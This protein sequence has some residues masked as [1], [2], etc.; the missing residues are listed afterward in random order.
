MR[1]FRRGRFREKPP[2]ER[3]YDDI[4]VASYESGDEIIEESY[5]TIVQGDVSTR[6]VYGAI[7]PSSSEFRI[8]TPSPAKNK[9]DGIHCTLERVEF[10]ASTGTWPAYE[11]L[12]YTWGDATV[13]RMIYVNRLPF[14]V[15]RNLDVA[16]RYLRQRDEPRVLWI[17]AV[18]IDQSN[19]AE[20]THQ[21]GMMGNI[22]RNAARVLVWLGESDKDIR[23]AMAFLQRAD[24]VEGSLPLDPEVAK[25]LRQPQQGN[26]R[27]KGK[28]CLFMERC[29]SFAPGI[30][31]MFQKPWW[32]KALLFSDA[33]GN[34]FRGKWSESLCLML[35]M[36]NWFPSILFSPNQTRF[37][38]SQ[39]W[40]LNILIVEFEPQSLL[41]CF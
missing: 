31:K 11:E 35:D 25:L 10:E 34:G 30:N 28:H 8:L 40:Y 7:D 23:K 22:Y 16:L 21:V 12:S 17:D 13:R 27:E 6:L 20:K 24:E 32:R 38:G 3:L 41:P 14:Q 2:T 37:F 19:L 9:T 33:A 1:L 39:S 15:T 18:C 5:G 4:S 36:K 26:E 29:H